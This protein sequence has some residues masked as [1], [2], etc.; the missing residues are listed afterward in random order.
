MVVF[1]LFVF[2]ARVTDNDI[3]VCRFVLFHV[4]ILLDNNRKP[5]VIDVDCDPGFQ[6]LGSETF[7][8]K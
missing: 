8:A 6:T 7:R 1:N 3:D 2:I 5:H 4:K